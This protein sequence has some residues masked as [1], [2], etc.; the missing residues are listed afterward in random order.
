MIP[1]HRFTMSELQIPDENSSE[2]SKGRRMSKTFT[3]RRKSLFKA[4]NFQTQVNHG[5]RRL[6][7]AVLDLPEEKEKPKV[8]MENTYKMK[9]DEDKQF[10]S[11]RVQTTVSDVLEEYLEDVKYDPIT[12]SRLVCDISQDIKSR[13]KDLNFIR[14]KIVVNVIIGQC[15]EQGL[16]VAS[17]CVWDSKTDTYTTV[18]Y[19]NRSLFAIALIHG[20]FLE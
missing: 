15:S 1:V 18:T 16:E 19:K 11:N 4:L 8:R 9:P 2:Q 13:V 5:G 3:T 7:R 10:S 12:C 20:L 6:T 14:Y 17:R